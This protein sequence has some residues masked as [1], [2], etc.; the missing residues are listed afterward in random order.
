MALSAWLRVGWL[1]FAAD[2]AYWMFGGSGALDDTGPPISSWHATVNAF[3]YFGG[4]VL[5]FALLVVSYLL[6]RVN[7]RGRTRT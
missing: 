3:L 5:F 4:W 6:W 7:E 2:V 1:V